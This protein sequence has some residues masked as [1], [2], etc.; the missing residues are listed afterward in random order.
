MLFSEQ[1]T[2]ANLI[3]ICNLQMNPH[4]LQAKRSTYDARAYCS[5][6][7]L[8]SDLGAEREMENK[9]RVFALDFEFNLLFVVGVMRF[10]WKVSNETAT[11]PSAPFVISDERNTVIIAFISSLHCERIRQIPFQH[12]CLCKTVSIFH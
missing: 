7:F 5:L 9:S 10:L 3:T 12:V 4:F 2:P 11:G 1:L 6:R 8:S